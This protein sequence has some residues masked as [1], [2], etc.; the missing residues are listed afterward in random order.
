MLFDLNRF[1]AGTYKQEAAKIVHLAWP[2]FIAQIAQVGVGVVDTVMALR[3][4]LPWHWE[5]AC[6]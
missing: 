6:L 3:I 4:W 2:M 5:P 1:G